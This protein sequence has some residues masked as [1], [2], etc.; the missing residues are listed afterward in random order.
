MGCGASSAQVKQA[1][2]EKKPQSK[3]YERK[4]QAQVAGDE[5][6]Q[7]A[8]WDS[9]RGLDEHVLHGFAMSTSHSTSTDPDTAVREAY[10]AMDLA[11]R[12]P[13][14]GEK[15]ATVLHD[16]KPHIVFVFSSPNYDAGKVSDALVDVAPN[17][18]VHG[19]SSSMGVF[20]WM[21]SA[22]EETSP[23][24]G[25]V[26]VIGIADSD[27]SFATACAQF[28]DHA[29]VE[30]TAVSAAE[31]ARNTLPQKKQDN[32]SLVVAHCSPRAEIAVLEG[33][34]DSAYNS[35][36]FVSPYHHVAVS[37]CVQCKFL[38]CSSHSSL[39]AHTTQQRS[40]RSAQNFW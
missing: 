15:G 17:V 9:H 8:S 19:T 31:R 32:I 36:P 13:E 21:G 3:Y 1:P 11:L 30:A 35:S 39:R 12:L 22:Q 20:T 14:R 28:E 25:G 10:K 7:W 4:N 18:P 24:E 37:M 5:K 2:A 26:A 33:T 23:H 34:C 38:R 29:S 40:L 6:K 27:G 16:V